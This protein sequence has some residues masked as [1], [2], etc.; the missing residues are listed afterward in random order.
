MDIDE[1]VFRLQWALEALVKEPKK[2][3]PMICKYCNQDI[4]D[5]EVAAHMGRIG[6]LK[7]GAIGGKSTS[8]AKQR[9][10]R[11]NGKKGGRPKKEKDAN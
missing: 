10:S 4:P 3:T 7:G 11:E 6:G 8:E 2:E 9:A 5:T 1:L